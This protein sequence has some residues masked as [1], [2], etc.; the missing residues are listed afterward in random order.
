[1]KTNASYHKIPD[2]NGV[3]NGTPGFRSDEPVAWREYVT[4]P[5]GQQM[6]ELAI[7]IANRYNAQDGRYDNT[8]IGAGGSDFSDVAETCW[9]FGFAG[10]LDAEAFFREFA[11]R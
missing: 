5:K 2:G 3:G 10:L 6:W 11:S 4:S 8:A 9:I 1:M 7:A